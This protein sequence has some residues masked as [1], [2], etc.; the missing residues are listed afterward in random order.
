[1]SVSDVYKSKDW[2]NDKAL[3]NKED[4]KKLYNQSITDPLF[5]WDEQGKRLD[6]YTPY[7]KIRD[8]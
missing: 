2:V 4:Y 1:M 3:I 6:W 5:F 8:Y 7:T